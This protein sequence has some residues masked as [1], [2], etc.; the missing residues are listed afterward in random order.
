MQEGSACWKQTPQAL[1]HALHFGVPRRTC[2]RMCV[3]LA[4][5]C[6]QCTG[7]PCLLAHGRRDPDACW[8]RTS[9]A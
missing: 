6:C 7:N 4:H 3:W 2:S 9:C 8:G 1:L 5:A